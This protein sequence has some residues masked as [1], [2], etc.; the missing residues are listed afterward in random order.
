MIQT[1]EPIPTYP[2]LNP[3]GL[4]W[5]WHFRYDDK[6]FYSSDYKLWKMI[7]LKYT[8][9]ENVVPRFRAS[10]ILPFPLNPPEMSLNP[11]EETLLQPMLKTF[12]AVFI[13]IKG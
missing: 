4:L 11:P 7:G 2:L 13:T 12:I 5:T 8:S 1:R 6:L 10:S 9:C 3:V